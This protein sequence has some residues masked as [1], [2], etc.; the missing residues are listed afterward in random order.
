MNI[1]NPKFAVNPDRNIFSIRKLESEQLKDNIREIIRPAEELGF[2]LKEFDIKDARYTGGNLSRTIKQNVVVKLEKNNSEI[3]LSMSIPKLVN[4]NY[5]IISGRK[6]IPLFQLFDIP[7]I[8]RGKNIKLRTN[9]ATVVVYNEKKPPYIRATILGRKV[10]FSLLMFSYYNLKD[11]EKKFNLSSIEED[12]LNLEELYNRFLFD[13]KQLYKEAIDEEK[14]E[15]DFIKDLGTFYNKNNARVKGTDVIYA[16]EI[17]LKVDPMSAKFLGSDNILEEIIKVIKEGEID[18]TDFRNKR[19]RCYEYMVLAKYSKAIFDL[20]LSNRTQRQ[21]KF[22]VNSSQILSECNVSDIVQFD[23]SINPIDELTKLSRISLVGPGGFDKQN[24]PE[25]LRDIDPS[26]FGRVCPVDTPDR[27]NCGVLQNLI[28]NTKLDDNLRFSE[29]RL[30]EQIIS[31]PVSMVPFSEH[32]DQTRLQMASSQMRQAILLKNFERPLIESGSEG[33]YTD[34]TQF[35]KRAKKDGDVVY[36]DKNY[37][38]VVYEDKTTDVFDISYRKIYVSNMDVFNVYVEQSDKFKAGDILAESLFCEDGRIHIGRNLLTAVMIH[39]GYNYEDGIVISD[40]LV[41]DGLLTSVH[42]VDLS[43]NIPP[44]KVLMSLTNDGEFNPLPEVGSTVN[45][46]DHYAILKEIPAGNIAPGSNTMDWHSIFEEEIPMLSK[47]NTIITDV[48]LY[49]NKWNEEIPQYKEFIEKKIEDQKKSEDEFHGILNE[50]LPDGTSKRFIKENRLDKFSHSGKYKLKGDE[51]N[52]IHVE[53]YG[54][55]FKPIKVG[56]KIGNRHGNK[57]V[58]ANI[59]PHEKMPQLEDGRHVEICINPLGI[60]SRMNIGQ[61]FE[62]HTAMSLNDLKQQLYKSNNETRKTRLLE[63]I[64]ILDNTEDNWYYNQFSTQL[65]ENISDEFLDKLTVIQ[66][67]FE[68]STIE[69]VKKALEYTGTNFTYNIKDP[70]SGED[71]LNPIA[72]G[73]M[74]F[75]RMVHIADSRLA[76]RGIASYA[77]RTLQPLAGRKNKGGQRC[78]EMETAC[79]IAHNAPKNLHEF[80][81][82]KSDCIDLKNQYI[83]NKIENDSFAETEVPDE[84]SESVKLLN[85]YLTVLGVKRE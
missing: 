59:V 5:V 52:G 22:N 36:L 85:A 14:T 11:L 27:E 32:D 63:F 20:C 34:Q 47:Q 62:L 81:T 16:I 58:I 17:M 66:P 33:L 49:I 44:N 53:M 83:R 19:V 12:E 70:I 74:N 23:F 10:P 48:N 40:K 56:D 41:K 57:G 30:E 29:E 26:M 24:I 80:Q 9:A 54:I 15:D 38:I 68:S 25:H 76:A 6:K 39:Y 8:T 69:Q 43:F 60:I 3:D 64:K 35:V 1:V 45:N 72:V 7:V 42:F 78:G 21:P 4:D 55:Y 73:Y 61:L 2:E 18:D 46:G 67:P 71:V 79:L 65:P 84:V 82:T 51:V 31:I 75:F 28:P 13:M 77:K 50:H 37:I